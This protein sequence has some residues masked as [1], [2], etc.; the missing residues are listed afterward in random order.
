MENGEISDEQISASSELSS[1]NAASQGRL[2][3]MKSGDN[4][5]TWVAAYNNGDQ[6]LQIN[7]GN[8]TRVT[9]VAT[10]GRN[11][12]EHWITKYN[13]Q[14]SDYGVNFPYYMEQGQSSKKV[15][16]ILGSFFVMFGFVIVF[17]K[18]IKVI[19]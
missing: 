6:W 3:L 1:S 18:I 9:G 10:Q 16:W 14:Y 12:V 17:T 8:Q 5:G 15:K 4:D 7:L 2:N 19:I 13:L 11:G